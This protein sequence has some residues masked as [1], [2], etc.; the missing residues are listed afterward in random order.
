M[1]QI[2]PIH[3]PVMKAMRPAAGAGSLSGPPTAAPRPPV[4]VTKART[5]ILEEMAQAAHAT[6]DKAQLGQHPVPQPGIKAAD[7]PPAPAPAAPP[8]PPPV[9][10]QPADRATR[11]A[12]TGLMADVAAPGSPADARYAKMVAAA[13]PEELE[14]AAE[15]LAGRLKRVFFSPA[16]EK[17]TGS[18][19][20][21]M[22]LLGNTPG[23][24][25]LNLGARLG[26]GVP[27]ARTTP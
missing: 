17:T 9:K 10:P 19:P 5:D 22:E 8:P 13:D 25:A 21:L 14:P 23:G 11:A 24:K 2:N 20:K 27:S 7:G 12:I 16:A 6:N 26:A 3:M 4:P 18:V 1:S 15:N